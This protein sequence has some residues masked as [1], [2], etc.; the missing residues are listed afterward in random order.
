LIQTDSK[1]FKLIQT[2]SNFILSEQDLS[3]LEE[4]EG[5]YGF[6]G[7]KERNNFLYRIFFIFEV[8]FE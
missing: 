8:D 3:E 1:D 2:H 6:E 5:K 4:F 7:F